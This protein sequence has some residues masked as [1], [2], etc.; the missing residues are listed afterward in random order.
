[1][2]PGP[3]RDRGARCEHRSRNLAGL[4]DSGCTEEVEEELRRHAVVWTGRLLSVVVADNRSAARTRL[5]RHRQRLQR[6]V[7]RNQRR[8]DGLR[9]EDGEDA[10]V[11]AGHAEGYLRHWL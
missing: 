11:E 7:C 6:S 2:Q 8:G 10:L 9:S 1:M 3:W 5:R 4:H